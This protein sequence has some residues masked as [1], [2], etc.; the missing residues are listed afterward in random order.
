MDKKL[1]VV[2]SIHMGQNHRYNK[3]FKAADVVEVRLKVIEA[4]ARTVKEGAF[5]CDSML[6][7][8]A[9]FFNNALKIYS[10]EG[11]HLTAMNAYN[12]G[13]YET[14]DHLRI[15]ELLKVLNK[16]GCNFEF[17]STEKVGYDK[18][19][20]VALKKIAHS[21]KYDIHKKRSRA[22]KVDLAKRIVWDWEAVALTMRD[23]G[24]VRN[25]L[26]N[27]LDE[28]ILYVGKRHR[29]ETLSSSGLLWYRIDVDSYKGRNRV[30]GTI[31]FHFKSNISRSFSKLDLT[32]D[33]KLEY[34]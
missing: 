1:Y 25:V 28:N 3:L 15:L 6:S 30:Y 7:D 13:D 16:R 2:S 17:K 27:G 9:D 5:F 22:E 26:E 10:R 14:Y 4:L 21:G 20:M 33:K 29:L 31:P 8:G 34:V 19:Q 32:I 11:I 24:I 18:V 23:R 12:E